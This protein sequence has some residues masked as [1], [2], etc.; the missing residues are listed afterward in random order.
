MIPS[1]F[2]L[3]PISSTVI[4]INQIKV[5][6]NNPIY[7]KL[8]EQEK[9]KIKSLKNIANLKPYYSIYQSRKKN[10]LAATVPAIRVNQMGETEKLISFTL[11]I[12]SNTNSKV[13]RLPFKS[14]KTSSVLSSG[15]WVKVKVDG[16]GVYKITYS[17]LQSFG[18]LNIP[19]IVTGKQ[20]GRAHV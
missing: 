9:K 2:E 1:Y 3:F 20:I 8:S 16:S 14:Y 15:K 5:S 7:I 19:T 17:E 18:L 6:I 13:Q 4:N 12:E 10:F 11:T